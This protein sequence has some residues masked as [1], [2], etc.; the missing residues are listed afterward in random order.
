MY[1]DPKHFT[2]QTL[3]KLLATATEQLQRFMVTTQKTIEGQNFQHQQ[4]MELEEYI[5]AIQLCLNEHCDAQD[6]STLRPWIV[7]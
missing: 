6:H 3:E 5:T 2:P 4:I 7:Q 1:L